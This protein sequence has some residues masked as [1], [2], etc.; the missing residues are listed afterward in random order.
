[1]AAGFTF[2]ETN[3]IEV[4]Y[5]FLLPL[6]VFVAEHD[7]CVWPSSQVSKLVKGKPT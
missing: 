5:L 6:A 2:R 7:D 3:Q 4:I 1:M